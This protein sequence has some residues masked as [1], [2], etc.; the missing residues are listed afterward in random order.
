LITNFELFL[1]IFR[2]S[3]NV[4]IIGTGITYNI[5]NEYE[6]SEFL[7]YIT[8]RNNGKKIRYQI[9]W[10]HNNIHH[11]LIK[12]LKE[13]TDIKNTLEF[14][15]LTRNFLNELFNENYSE[16]TKNGNYSLWL[17]EYNISFIVNINHKDKKIFFV[18]FFN[19][20]TTSNVINTIELKSTI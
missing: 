17:S 14:K 8:F 2:L 5:S 10:N 1:E 12:K 3:D 19:G 6:I 13:K 20:C 15:S 16:I 11:N 7:N 4:K 9:K 18:T